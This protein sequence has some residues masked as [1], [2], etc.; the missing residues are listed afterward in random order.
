MSARLSRHRISF[1][2]GTRR[3][4]K[5]KPYCAYAAARPAKAPA[6]ERGDGSR[7]MIELLTTR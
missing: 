3:R 5:S 6:P 7:S 4:T 2:I 1:R